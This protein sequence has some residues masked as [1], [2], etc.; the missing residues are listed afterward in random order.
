MSTHAKPSVI[1][2]ISLVFFFL[3]A[4]C[5]PA[6]AEGTP[7]L[8]ET[9]VKEIRVWVAQLAD[10]EFQ[11]RQAAEDALKKLPRHA[12]PLLREYANADDPEV[13]ARIRDVIE[14]LSHLPIDHMLQS[15]DCNRHIQL[16]RGCIGWR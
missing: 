8:D 12:I 15:I 3:A 7:T 11:R 10:I 16:F 14:H 6:A 2:S 5:S 1:V 9:Q 13:R 4:S